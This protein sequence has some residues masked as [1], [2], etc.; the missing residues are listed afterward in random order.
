MKNSYFLAIVL[1]FLLGGAI[2]LNQALAQEV[3]T[4]SADP[5]TIN[6]SESGSVETRETESVVSL[7]ATITSPANNAT[8][9]LGQSIT[10]SASATGGRP[11]Y[12][13]TWNFGDGT[14]AF[15]QTY[16]K[17]Y[18]TAGTRTVTLTVTDFNGVQ[19]NTSI[20]VT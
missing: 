8:F 19:K 18:T 7:G 11:P 16:D 2:L 6:T 17:T 5:V 10:F 1:L 20:S 15:G 13:Y 14:E 9:N 4:E 12:A 3:L